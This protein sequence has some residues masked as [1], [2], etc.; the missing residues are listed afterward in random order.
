MS[1]RNY[2]QYCGLARALDIV[3]NRWSLLVVRELLTGPRRFGELQDGLPGIATNL[4]TDRLRELEEDGVVERRLGTDRNGVEYALTEWGAELRDSID[5]LIRWSTPTM[6]TGRAEND[7]FRPSWLPVPLRALSHGRRS[8]RAQRV[9]FNVEESSIEFVLDQHGPRVN[10]SEFDPELPTL[11]P[12]FVLGVTA[13]VPVGVVAS[14]VGLE[15]ALRDSSEL[16]EIAK[17]LAP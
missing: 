10:V 3:G 6:V 2:R 15:A 5:A 16:D 4:L 8:R 1:K 13:G 11:P 7:A 17:C 14:A 9:R 12:E